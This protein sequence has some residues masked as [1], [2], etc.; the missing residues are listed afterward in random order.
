MVAAVGGVEPQ[1]LFAD[2][3]PHR[4][5]GGITLAGYGGDRCW[6]AGFVEEA[7]DVEAGV[8]H[9][10]H[11]ATSTGLEVQ[12]SPGL[13]VVVDLT[14]GCQVR[15]DAR[16]RPRRLGAPGSLVAVAMTSILV[17]MSSAGCPAG[18]GPVFDRARLRQVRRA[19]RTLSA[20]H[21]SLGEGNPIRGIL[22]G[23]CWLAICAIGTLAAGSTTLGVRRA[24]PF[25]PPRPSARLALLGASRFCAPRASGRLALLRASRFWARVDPLQFPVLPGRRMT[26]LPAA[27]AMAGLRDDSRSVRFPV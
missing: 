13:V 6:T 19:A 15:G 14:L 1:A 2:G 18:V 17:S 3:E 26:S 11:D 5:Q 24:S 10:T 12:R 21:P 25:C 8:V 9:A 16:I 7:Q 22:G 4:R 20:W 27:R 23:G